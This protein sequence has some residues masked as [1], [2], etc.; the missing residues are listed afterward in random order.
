MVTNR[1]DILDRFQLFQGG[2]GGLDSWIRESTAES[3]F[4]ALLDLNNRPLTRA[5]FNQLLTISHEAPM[6][7]AFFRYYWLKAPD[8]HPVMTSRR[9]PASIPVFVTL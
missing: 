6:S 9:F 2:T 3:V 7:E 1:K 5:R 4:T 8:H